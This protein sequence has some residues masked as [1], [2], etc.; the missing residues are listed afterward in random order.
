MRCRAGA[1]S[2]GP[3]TKLGTVPVR[4]HVDPIRRDTELRVQL[5]AA[6]LVVDDHAVR[7]AVGCARD[8]RRI[9]PGVERLH[10]VGS[11][12]HP[13]PGGSG[14]RDAEQLQRSGSEEVEMRHCRAGAACGPDARHEP[15]GEAQTANGC[16]VVAEHAAKPLGDGKWEALGNLGGVARVECRFDARRGQSATQLE[17][18][19]VHAAVP[20]DGLDDGCTDLRRR[21]GLIRHRAAAVAGI[22][23][24]I[25]TATMVRIT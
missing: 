1:G 10:V 11:D 20:A 3:G 19:V 22:D 4:N 25:H 12:D 18:V 17:I 13:P 15:G 21:V 9:L 7:K 8:P 16:G 24:R 6:C 2:A 23:S 5:V 14:E